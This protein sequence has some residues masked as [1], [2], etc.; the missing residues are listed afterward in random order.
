MSLNLKGIDNLRPGGPAYQPA[1]PVQQDAP[2]SGVID[3]P[4]K[5]GLAAILLFFGVFGGW[6][7]FAPLAGGAV[8]Q[9]VISPLGARRVVQHLEGGIIEEILVR[10]GDIVQAGDPLVVLSST[11]AQAGFDIYKDRQYTLEAEIA[12]L[13]AEQA[14]EAALTFPTTLTARRGEAAMA[15]ILD[16]QKA[17]F[18]SRRD[19]L[20]AQKD[21]LGQRVKQLKEQIGGLRAQVAA[22]DKQLG[23]IDDE[24]RD[25]RS[26]VEKGLAPKPR[27]LA[28]HRSRAELEGRRAEDMSAI[29]SAGQSIGEAEL[30]MVNLNAESNANIA[31]ALSAAQTALAEIREQMVASG[32]V[33]DRTT[34]LAPVS[35][36]VINRHFATVGG[37]VRGG[38]SILEIVPE[39]DELIIE[40]RISPLDIDVVHEGLGAQVALSAYAQRNLP[41]LS[42]TV[43]S[44][45]ADALTDAITGEPYFNAMIEVDRA[46]LSEVALETGV[47]LE[48]TPGMPAQV[49]V[50]TGHRTFL[51]YLLQ[52]LLGSMRASFRET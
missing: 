23:F 21:I 14:G 45:S 29:A 6:A 9:G 42:G 15:K 35:G 49:L 30:Q 51:Q 17:L 43:R 38:E 2:F 19:T 1:A 31:D 4:L 8:A 32:D 7:A 10:N 12:R 11:Q 20:A 52:P 24:I 36:A 16:A 3:R 50:V 5:I 44:V 37:V 39:A 48:L 26:L 34:I 47:D 46:R 22:S 41:R 18:V 27:L 25:V 33:L 40:A 28:L 13:R